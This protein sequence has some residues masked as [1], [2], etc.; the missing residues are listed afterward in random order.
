LFIF[1][2][3]HPAKQIDTGIACSDT[4]SSYDENLDTKPVKKRKVRKGSPEDMKV[5]VIL[6]TML[7]N[8][9]IVMF[10]TYSL[11]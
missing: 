7:G 8:A 6:C 9:V 11:I 4:G 1:L 2:E 5:Y 10:L 3:E